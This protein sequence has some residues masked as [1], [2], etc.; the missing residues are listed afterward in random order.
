MMAG[1]SG[2]CLCGAVR[3]SFSGEPMA[4]AVC[5]CTHC[6]RQSGAAFSTN[7]VVPET[8]YSQTGETTT[9]LDSGDS[10]H[11]VERRFCGRCG[12][13]ILSK[14]AAMPAFVMVKAGTLDEPLATAPGMELYTDHAFAWV[15]PVPGARR[16]A[17]AAG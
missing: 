9:F 6:Q 7:L 8:A 3:Y 13:P 15:P 4:A 16:F 11:P 17:Q 10:G 1:H 14:I 12:S 2:G 5:H